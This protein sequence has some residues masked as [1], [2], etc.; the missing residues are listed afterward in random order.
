M[1]KLTE[2]NIDAEI[3]RL[4]EQFIEMVSKEPQSTTERLMK[5]IMFQEPDRMPAYMQIHDHAAR[6]AG[7]PLREFC[8][9]HKKAFYASLYSAIRYKYD[10]AVSLADAYNFE[11]EALGAK[12]LFPEDSFPV[13]LESLIEEAG[14]LE[15]LDIPDFDKSGRGPYIV[16]GLKLNLEKL[17]QYGYPASIACAPW[18]LA[19]QIRGFN[20]LVRDTRKN[21]EFAHKILDFCVDVIEAFVKYQQE[22]VG[23]PLTLSMAD[24]FSCIPPT[25]P[26]LVY[27]YVIPHTADIIKRFG[28]ANWVGGYPIEEVPGWEQIFED[29]IVKTGA[30]MGAVMMLESDWLPPVKIKEMSN[31]LRKPW[32]FGVRAGIISKWTPEQI[33]NHVKN[34]I[35][36]LA[37]GG[38]CMVIGDQIPRDTPPENLQT[39]VN[40][41]KKYGKYPIS[42]K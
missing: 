30:L 31:K 3:D 25:S 27:D 15:K 23:L 2:E 19:V 8:T 24:A 1:V 37:P 17:G 35:K 32:Y 6:V 22:S 21:P 9:D 12:M 13:I 14:D 28:M 38:G 26:Q 11:A 41:I 36:V 42:I 39:F 34:L 18:S 10:I 20:N 4:A 16:E 33:E 5:I 40:S 29:V 7:I